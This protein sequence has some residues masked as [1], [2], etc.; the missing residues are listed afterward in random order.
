MLVEMKNPIAIHLRSMIYTSLL[1]SARTALLLFCLL[2]LAGCDISPQ[3]GDQL[4]AL[5]NPT[6]E[7]KIPEQQT[8][9]STVVASP[10]YAN[11]QIDSRVIELGATQPGQSFEQTL[12]ITNAGTAPL[13]L[14][15]YDKNTSIALLGSNTYT[16]PPGGQGKVSFRWQPSEKPGRKQHQ[17]QF[18]TNDP[19]LS[20][21]EI[22]LFGE[23]VSTLAADPPQLLADRVHPDR[24]A[25]FSTLITSQRWPEFALQKIESDLPGTTWSVEPATQEQLQ[26]A[27]ALAGWNLTVQLPE[28]LPDGQLTQGVLHLQAK[29]ADPQD[30]P[31][32][33]ELPIRAN[34]LR[35]LAVY[36]G[37]IDE[38]GTVN[39]GV[40]PTGVAYH[41]RLIVKVNDAEPHLRLE[42]IRTTP[43]FLQAKLL[44]YDKDPSQT[45]LYYLDLEL[46]ADAPEYVS[47]GPQLGEVELTFADHPRIRRLKLN[48]DFVLQGKARQQLLELTESRP[49]TT[50]EQ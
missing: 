1:R 44:P 31:Q 26:Q 17:M 33:L 47:R 24:P 45:D 50:S 14:K 6:R 35:R 34:V 40:Q 18:Q 16:I 15:R 2:G 8:A 19:R 4:F 7:W 30:S 36:G 9:D 23:V 27:N 49:P 32:K 41:R 38:T 37:G 20:T 21:L 25:A 5:K 22:Q 28:D 10:G 12:T 3:P 43:D 46:P 48:V 11:L 39:F 29:P 13:Q 42:N